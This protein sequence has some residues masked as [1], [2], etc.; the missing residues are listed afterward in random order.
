[1]KSKSALTKKDII[2]V[3]ACL[4]FLLANLGLV[5]SNGREHAKRMV[6]ATNIRQSFLAM[7]RFSNDNE[8][9]LPPHTFLPWVW[10][11]SVKTCDI[12]LK[13]G[14]TKNTLYCPSNKQQKRYRKEYWEYA[15]PMFR[16]T[17]YFWIIDA[18]GRPPIQGSGNKQWLR[19]IYIKNA[20]EAELITD[21]TLSD[22]GNWPHAEY[23]NGNFE[24]ILCS[25]MAVYPKVGY[26]TTNHLK[27]EKEPAGGNI[28]FADGHVDWRNF[29][30]MERRL[31]IP[32]SLIF[33]W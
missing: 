28:G 1:M 29:S 16:V 14:A 3:L 32:G 6:C 21:A 27:S 2:V 24:Q 4:V 10:D 22:V 13:Y 30:E 31:N 33:W 8:G 5:N 19:T 15:P 25:G 17:G 12:I 18:T 7:E 20:A 9:E 23:P 26:D 11:V